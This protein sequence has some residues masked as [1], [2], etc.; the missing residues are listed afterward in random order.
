LPAL[1]GEAVAAGSTVL[2][3]DHLGAAE[4]LAGVVRWLVRD[5]QVIAATGAGG[6]TCTVTVTVTADELPAVESALHNA[7][8]RDIAVSFP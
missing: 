7:G 1:L 5:G 8:V 3:S 2:V 4:R 6:P